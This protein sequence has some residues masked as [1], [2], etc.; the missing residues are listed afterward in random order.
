MVSKKT[1]RPVHH[2]S[3]IVVIGDR[4]FTDVMLANMMGAWSIWVK[5]GV[6]RD[7]GVVSDLNGMTGNTDENSTQFSSLE[8]G[9]PSILMRFGFRAPTPHAH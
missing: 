4:L 3:Q 1:K 8:K 7:D 6:V 9:L 2:P 5:D